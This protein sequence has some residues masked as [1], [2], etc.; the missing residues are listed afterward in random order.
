MYKKKKN[1]IQNIVHVY[2]VGQSFT[3][4]TL[5]LRPSSAIMKQEKFP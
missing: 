4:T 2:K 1:I 3:H 5:L